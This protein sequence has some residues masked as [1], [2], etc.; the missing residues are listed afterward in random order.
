VNIVFNHRQFSIQRVF[1]SATCAHQQPQLFIVCYCWGQL[2]VI[3]IHLQMSLMAK[4]INLESFVSSAIV[5]V[6]C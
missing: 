6:P 5:C 2:C 1:K 4:S 3:Y